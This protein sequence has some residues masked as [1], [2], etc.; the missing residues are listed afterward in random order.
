MSDDD[1]NDP[2]FDDLP[3]I[4]PGSEVRD[5]S[6]NR[7]ES[8][9]PAIENYEIVSELGR[10][11]MGVVYKARDV[12]LDRVVALKM[13]LGGKFASE[14]EIQRFR[15]EGESAARLD[16]PGIVPI[17]QIEEFNG[18][19]FFSMK[20]VEG[21]SLLNCLDDYKS[22]HRNAVELVAKIA[23]AVQHANQRAV[24]H[25]DLKPANILIDKSGQPAITDFGLAKRTDG[26][27]ELTATGLVMGTPGFMS[28]NRLLA[29]K[30]SQRQLMY[31]L[32]ERFFIGRS[33]GKPR[34]RARREFRQ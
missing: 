28:P 23:D 3:T 17:Y 4:L 1:Q 13:I 24:L 16:H 25:R 32:W 9:F 8:S 5:D 20:F 31:F 22:D 15:I 12:R 26:D 33:R 7:V 19:H 14:E 34:F 18:N 21:N 2:S 11:G 29:A 30:T 27:S 10:G 6:A